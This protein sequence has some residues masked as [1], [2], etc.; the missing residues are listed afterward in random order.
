MHETFIASSFYKYT[1]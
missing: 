1:L